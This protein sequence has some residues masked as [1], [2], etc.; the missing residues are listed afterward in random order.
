MTISWCK[1]AHTRS[2]FSSINWHQ[3]IDDA[4]NSVCGGGGG[5]DVNLRSNEYR[6]DKK[7]TMEGDR[8]QRVIIHQV[9]SSV[10][11]H[12]SNCYFRS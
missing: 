10:V 11:D 8:T 3:L 1:A 5:I 12:W 6:Y 9:V 7:V 2:F 4:I